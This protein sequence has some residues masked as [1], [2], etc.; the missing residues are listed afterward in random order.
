MMYK[1]KCGEQ[2]KK[3]DNFKNIKIEHFIVQSQVFFF[4]I[5]TL[6]FTSSSSGYNL[7]KGGV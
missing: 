7:R 5:L 6:S 3:T 4:I 1:R 2:Q